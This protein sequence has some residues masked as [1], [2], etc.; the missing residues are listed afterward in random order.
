MRIFLLVP[1][2]QKLILE[3]IEALSFHFR[4]C[5]QGPI[6]CGVMYYV[7][8]SHMHVSNGFLIVLLCPAVVLVV[9]GMLCSLP[10]RAVRGFSIFAACWMII[11]G[12]I[13][14]VLLPACAPKLQPASFVFQGF[15][16]DNK[17]AFGIPNNA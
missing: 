17:G 4:L 13:L 8:C 14:F 12:A 3:H 16:T 1:G 15:T 2:Q 10:T 5:V 11:A 9:S 7:P 6:C